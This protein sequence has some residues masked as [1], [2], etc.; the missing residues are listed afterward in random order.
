MIKREPRAEE[1]M[2]LTAHRR[3]LKIK[4]GHRGTEVH[5]T[6]PDQSAAVIAFADASAAA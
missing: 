3:G 6:P 4:I 5:M 2:A 1:V